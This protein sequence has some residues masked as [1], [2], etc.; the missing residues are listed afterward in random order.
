G[1]EEERR[2]AARRPVALHRRS[3][4]DAAGDRLSRRREETGRALR[5]MGAQAGRAVGRGGPYNRGPMKRTIL[6]LFAIAV[7]GGLG[8]A[9]WRLWDERQFASTPY[10]D[11]IRTVVVPPGTG[12][13]ALSR[14]LVDAHAVSDEKRFYVHLHWF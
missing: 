12:P 2:D 8:F 14:L 9:G 4:I 5:Q 3:P 10:G 13:H 11:G 1:R 6:W 7:L